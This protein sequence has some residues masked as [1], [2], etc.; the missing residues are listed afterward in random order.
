[1]AEGAILGSEVT[2]KVHT[3]NSFHENPKLHENLKKI[4]EIS[5]LKD[6]WNGNRAAAFTESLL[7]KAKLII[8]SL[9]IQPYIF[10]TAA[11]SIQLEY[12]TDKGYLEFEISESAVTMF[13]IFQDGT[14]EESVIELREINNIV[15]E[16]YNE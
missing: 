15:Q 10:P 2:V 13:R 9:Y 7:E 8:Y 4:E 11:E 16:F 14:E 12:E 1:M 6:D 5:L 3:E